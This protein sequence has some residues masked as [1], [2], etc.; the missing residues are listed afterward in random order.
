MNKFLRSRMEERAKEAS[1]ASEAEERRL[2]SFFRGSQSL[3]SQKIQVLDPSQ[4]CR[5]F[6]LT[7]SQFRLQGEE[8]EEEEGPLDRKS[9][10]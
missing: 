3:S 9:V 8:E 5:S 1:E 7:L 10:V 2:L 6:Y 4:D